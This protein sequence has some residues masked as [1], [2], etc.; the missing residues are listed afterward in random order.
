MT[1]SDAVY[2]AICN[3]L[4]GP[5]QIVDWS[6][7]EDSQWLLFRQYTDFDRE[8]IG[9]LLYWHFE[10]SGWPESMPG[11]VRRTLADR[12]YESAAQNVLLL[13]ELERILAALSAAQIPAVVLKGAALLGLI[14]ENIGLRPMG[15]LDILVHRQHLA[16]ARE[17]LRELHYLPEAPE[18][19]PGIQ[20]HIDHTEAWRGG[21]RQRVGLEIHWQLI[22]GAADIRHVPAEQFWRNVDTLIPTVSAWSGEPVCVLAP[23]YQILYLC[24]HLKLRHGGDQERLIWYYDLYQYIRANQQ[25]INWDELTKLA[26]RLRWSRVLW[27][28]LNGVEARFGLTLP[29]DFRD[30]VIRDCEAPGSVME[31]PSAAPTRFLQTWQKLGRLNWSSR[32]WLIGGL[33][34]PSPA[35][36]RWR[37]GGQSRR[38]WPM[39]YLYRWGD[40]WRDLYS[41]IRLK[42]RGPQPP[43]DTTDKNDSSAHS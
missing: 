6:A 9:P 27:R 34:F 29:Q 18:I 24:A 23:T 32:L 37:Y 41:T 8:G 30:A 20:N 43:V 7:F 22:A 14:Y 16:K 10:K 42:L 36:L 11:P 21:P 28:A 3:F 2:A 25:R 5:S 4:S 38:F 40:I 1:R 17:Q 13:G 26:R 12:F 35:Y 31:R 15:D 33:L 19:S 39:Y